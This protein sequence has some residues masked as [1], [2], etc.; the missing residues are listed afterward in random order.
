M[1]DFKIVDKEGEWF[2][3]TAQFR[4]AHGTRAGVVL[5]PGIPT[6]VESD[7]WIKSQTLLV[8]VEDPMGD[9]PAQ[10][11]VETPIN[12]GMPGVKSVP[13]DAP[14]KKK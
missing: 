1:A 14:T 8:K 4:F 12:G 2:V 7:E 11:T 10:I 3:N 5:D 6:K 13:A 9:L